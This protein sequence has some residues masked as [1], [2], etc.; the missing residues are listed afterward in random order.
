MPVRTLI[1]I[2]QAAMRLVDTHD[3]VPAANLDDYFK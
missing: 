1:K 2:I 3:R